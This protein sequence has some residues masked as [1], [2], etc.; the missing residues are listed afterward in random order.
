M[1]KELLSGHQ[2]GQCSIGTV[3][4]EPIVKR[5]LV[6]AC[7][8]SILPLSRPADERSKVTIVK[9]CPLRYPNRRRMHPNE[10]DAYLPLRPLL[11]R[12]RTRHRPLADRHSLDRNKASC[13]R[14]PV[15][16][17]PN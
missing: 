7:H 9:R 8:A 15:R 6:H 13:S 17:C 14:A 11:P 1:I 10:L 3:S 2:Q 16:R 12:P 5:V 4:E